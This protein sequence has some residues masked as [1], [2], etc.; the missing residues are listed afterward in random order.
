VAPLLRCDTTT[1]PGICVQCLTSADC[2]A[3]LVC[4]V[5]LS[6]RCLEC[7]PTNLGNCL[8]SGTGSFCLASGTCGCTT[9]ADCGPEGSGRVCD[10]ATSKCTF[11]CRGSGGNHCAPGWIC[12]ST[13]DALGVC[14]QVGTVC[15]NDPSFDGTPC[16]DDGV[17]WGGVC[18]AVK[19]TGSACTC[20]SS[21]G[22]GGLALAALLAFWIWRRRRTP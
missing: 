7:T 13:G 3:P 22:P 8:A 2:V 16:G 18:R 6:R 11:G 17:C 5:L 1:L 4:D 21:G 10:P 15:P 12:T 9:D 14:V 19:A 20:S